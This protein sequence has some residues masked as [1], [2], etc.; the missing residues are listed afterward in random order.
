MTHPT[1]HNTLKRGFRF[2]AGILFCSLLSLEYSVAQNQ[3]EMF[4]DFDVPRGRWNLILIDNIVCSQWNYIP[5]LGKRNRSSTAILGTG[6]GFEYAY[7]RN[8]TLSLTEEVGLTGYVLSMEP[9]EWGRDARY[10]NINL[11]HTSYWKHL[12]LSIGPTLGWNNWKY[13]YGEENF[14]EDEMS[15]CEK[16]GY[17]GEEDF[18]FTRFAA[19]ADIQFYYYLIP[20]LGFGVE[21]SAR[22]MWKAGAKGK[23]DHQCALKVRL[24]FRLNKKKRS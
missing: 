18:S 15:S 6:A 5:T 24:K 3:P 20:Q 4:W 17:Y 19:G 11:L 16:E 8:R 23:C 7:C 22:W 2:L 12:A 14:S 13:F 10:C 9:S 21:Y 1:S